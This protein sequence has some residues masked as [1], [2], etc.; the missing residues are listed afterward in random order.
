VN[1]NGDG[2]YAQYSPGLPV[3][4]QVL[5]GTGHIRTNQGVTS[6]QAYLPAFKNLNLVGSSNAVASSFGESGSGFPH[7]SGT[8]T[9]SGNPPPTLTCPAPT[10][11]AATAYSSAFVASGGT[12]PYTITFLSNSN[13]SL[14]LAGGPGG[15]VTGIASNSP[16]ST[17]ITARVTDSTGVSTITSCLITIST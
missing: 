6:I 1:A 12:P 7:L 9:L 17:T 14:G 5:T 8:F 2:T 16:G 10:G 3:N 4:Q 13:P 15:T 11:L